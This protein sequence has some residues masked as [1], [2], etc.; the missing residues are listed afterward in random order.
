MTKFCTF[1]NVFVDIYFESFHILEPTLTPACVFPLPGQVSKRSQHSF[2]C[3][4]D[5][6]LIAA[7]SVDRVLTGVNSQLNYLLVGQ[8]LKFTTCCFHNNKF[9][10]YPKIVHVNRFPTFLHSEMEKQEA[11]PANELSARTARNE[12][13]AYT[14]VTRNMSTRTALQ[15]LITKPNIIEF[16]QG[17]VNG[18]GNSAFTAQPLLKFQIARFLS[19]FDSPVLS[20]LLDGQQP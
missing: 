20:L 16:L 17:Y 12:D 9:P 18:S 11:N 3:W 7:V 14:L 6:K 5:I 8:I 15:K 4:H 1:T 13:D 10:D 19:N 2:V